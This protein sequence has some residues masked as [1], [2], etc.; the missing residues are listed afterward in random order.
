MRSL[1][2]A[3]HQVS[4]GPFPCHTIRGLA[5]RLLASSVGGYYVSISLIVS[6]S[7]H[8]QEGISLKEFDPGFF[9]SLSSRACCANCSKKSRLCPPG[10][11][12]PLAS[13]SRGRAGRLQAPGSP[14]AVIRGLGQTQA[15]PCQGR[16][17]EVPAQ[18]PPEAA[19]HLPWNSRH[20]R[21]KSPVRP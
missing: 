21:A 5:G 16:G 11:E 10:Q 13:G 12:E 3:R 4:R 6:K 8:K 20:S 15:S 18:V 14:A 17:S 1:S 9:A 19:Q 7:L 2:G